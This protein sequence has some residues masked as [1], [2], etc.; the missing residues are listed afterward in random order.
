MLKHLREVDRL[1]PRLAADDAADRAS[2]DLD[3]E[4]AAVAYLLRRMARRTALM[5][6]A[7]G[8]LADRHYSPVGSLA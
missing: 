4:R 6:P 7:M 8:A 5:R 1:G 2:V 3:D